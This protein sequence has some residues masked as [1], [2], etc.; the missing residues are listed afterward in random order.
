MAVIESQLHRI[1]RKTGRKPSQCKCK[2]CQKQCHQPC[3]GTPQ[4]IARLIDAGYKDRL[5]PT[6]WAA[7]MIMGVHKKP[8]FMVQAKVD[9]DW[10]TFFRDGLCEL[11]D[12]GLK[13]TEGRLSHHTI[14]ADNWS[15]KRS[16]S[17]HVAKEWLLPENL[18]TILWI[19]NE[20]AG[21]VDVDLA[22]N[23]GK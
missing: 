14:R 5:A 8:I 16:I 10:C 19:C 9:G 4:D 21:A 20:L 3:L 17:W 7:G 18:T 11:H 6:G 1:M 2:L 12:K 15:P 13:P 23:V 22:I